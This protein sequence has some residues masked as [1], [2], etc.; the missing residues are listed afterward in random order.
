M[1][2]PP[3]LRRRLLNKINETGTPF[4]VCAHGQLSGFYNDCQ[5]IPLLISSLNPEEEFRKRK[6]EVKVIRRTSGLAMSLGNSDDLSTLTTLMPN[7]SGLVTLIYPTTF[8]SAGTRMSYSNAVADARDAQVARGR[9]VVVPGGR[10]RFGEPL[11]QKISDGEKNGRPLA[12]KPRQ[13]LMLSDVNPFRKETSPR[14]R[15]EL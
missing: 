10:C 12:R 15:P 13:T 9:G 3:S 7:L 6:T 2:R 5:E 11:T 4:A 14:I 8:I 1:F